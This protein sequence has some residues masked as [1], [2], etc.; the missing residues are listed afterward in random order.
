MT[1]RVSAVV[2]SEARDAAHIN[3]LLR[4]A[5]LNNADRGICNEDEE[6]YGRFHEGTKWRRDFLVFEQCQHK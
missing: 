5:L 3:R 6:D 4:I 2:D 1:P